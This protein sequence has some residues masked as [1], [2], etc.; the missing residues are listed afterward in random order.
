MNDPDVQCYV[1]HLRAAKICCEGGRGWFAKHGWSWDD[2]ITNGR[3][4][5]DFIATG[6]PFALRMVSAAAKEAERGQG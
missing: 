2:F 4:S 1:R 5:S 3:H 6:D